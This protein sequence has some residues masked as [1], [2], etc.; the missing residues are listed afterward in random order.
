MT[1]GIL[2][3]VMMEKYNKNK[4]FLITMIIIIVCATM[5]NFGLYNILNIYFIKPSDVYS[6]V[7]LN[8]IA[9]II[10]IGIVTVIMMILIP[11]ENMN[12]LLANM[13]NNIV[14]KSPE[15][16]LQDMIDEELEKELK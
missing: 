10:I 2:Y 12:E 16:Q 3:K 14:D 11:K 6:G 13:E 8:I 9:M 4:K 1:N 5:V 15:Q 7:Q